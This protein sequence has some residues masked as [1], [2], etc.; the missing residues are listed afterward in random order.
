MVINMKPLF[1]E[2]SKRNFLTA[3]F[4]FFFFF[5]MALLAAYG[6]SWARD[7]IRATAAVDSLTHYTG[8]MAGDH[9]THTSPAI[10]AT[11]VILNPLCHFRN[12]LNYW[13]FMQPFASIIY[14]YMVIQPPLEEHE[15]HR[16]CQFSEGPYFYCSLNSASHC[17][18][19]L[20]DYKQ[21]A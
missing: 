17:G 4:F 1:P 2:L 5:L 19:E 6:N 13:I 15:G 21:G 12:S 18:R 7:W 14:R 16:I 9:R 10:R 3:G 20:H 8:K 11:A